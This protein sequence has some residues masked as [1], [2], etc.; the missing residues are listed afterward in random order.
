MRLRASIAADTA[1]AR[2]R[3]AKPSLGGRLVHLPIALCGGPL[4]GAARGADL[5][6]A[7]VA[8]GV[9]EVIST[10]TLNWT[11]RHLVESWLVPGPLA[12]R[13]TESHLSLPGRAKIWS[14]AEPPR[15]FSG[16]VGSEIALARAA[17]SCGYSGARLRLEPLD[18]RLDAPR[19]LHPFPMFAL[20]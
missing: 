7:Q 15:F 11:A 5:R 12:P 9:S 14:T 10:I 8:R 2:G 18:P 17:R 20:P 6:L 13:P 1:P 19:S 4:A 16:E 3:G